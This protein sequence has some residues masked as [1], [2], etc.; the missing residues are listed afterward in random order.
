MR[1]LSRVPV[2]SLSAGLRASV[3]HP[4]HASSSVR[5]RAL[6][7]KPV[8]AMAS[9]LTLAAYLTHYAIKI[10]HHTRPRYLGDSLDPVINRWQQQHQHVVFIAAK[11]L[12]ASDSPAPAV[13]AAA[14]STVSS[15]SAISRS[16]PPA[17]ADGVTL[18]GGRSH[19]GK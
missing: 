13:I 15:V 1:A 4:H 9:W 11:A 7:A 10:D 17:E 19:P 5:P 16:R 12:R 8:L 14:P 3:I 18:N 6:K 2:S